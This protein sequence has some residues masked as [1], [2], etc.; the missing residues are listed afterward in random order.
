MSLRYPSLP[1]CFLNGAHELASHAIAA[2]R[3]P[4]VYEHLA[5]IVQ[6]DA[7]VIRRERDPARNPVAHIGDQDRMLRVLLGGSDLQA[8][9]VHRARSESN[10]SS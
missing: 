2:E 4:H 5:D 8:L 6:R 10:V 1:G 9:V 7:V 3:P